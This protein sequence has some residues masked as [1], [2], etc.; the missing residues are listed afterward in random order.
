MGKRIEYI[1]IVT[2]SRVFDD[3]PDS[4]ARACA[5]HMLDHRIATL[6]EGSLVVSGGAERGPDAWATEFMKARGRAKDVRLYML[7]G[8]V[9]VPSD[10]SHTLRSW[11]PA[12][13]RVQSSDRQKW[14][15]YR[16]E[17]MIEEI[18]DFAVK[19]GAH[20]EVFGLE[21][22]W[23]ATRG[24]AYTLECADRAKIPVVRTSFN[25]TV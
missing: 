22:L 9:V 11:V 25:C 3:E 21:A 23:S 13:P 14:P 16:N 7:S 5:R 8:D 10:P 6:P 19:N 18:A 2:G 15:L 17:R 4:W 1:F 20:P 24:T 12:E